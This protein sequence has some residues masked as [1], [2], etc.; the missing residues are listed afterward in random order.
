M[1]GYEKY[2]SLG[3]ISAAHA[4]GELQALQA[5]PTP[6]LLCTPVND[7]R[8]HSPLAES[9]KH[10]YTRKTGMNWA[11]LFPVYSFLGLMAVLNTGIQSTIEYLWWLLKTACAKIKRKHT[12]EYFFVSISTKSTYKGHVSEGEEEQSNIQIKMHSH[13]SRANCRIAP[14]RSGLHEEPCT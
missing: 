3:V 5:A 2:T 7:C 11:A 8:Q 6:A 9:G 12:S 13:T 10:I 4:D 1:D 14:G